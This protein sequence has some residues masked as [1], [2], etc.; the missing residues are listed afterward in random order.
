MAG[1]SRHRDLAAPSRPRGGVRDGSRPRSRRPHD[2]GKHAVDTTGFAS[3][4]RRL[5]LSVHRLVPGLLR[6]R[7][8][9][10][11]FGHLSI[12][13]DQT[14][15]ID[16]GAA[17]PIGKELPVAPARMRIGDREDAKSLSHGFAP[18]S[19]ANPSWSIFPNT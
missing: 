6:V 11:A 12:I 10:A 2:V 5:G 17:S 16:V 18:P 15:G 9:Q 13:A 14:P 8:G 4:A 19:F 3:A 1:L 7:I